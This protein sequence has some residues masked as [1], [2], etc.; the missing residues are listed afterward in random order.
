MQLHFHEVLWREGLVLRGHLFYVLLH[1]AVE[2]F[3]HW[4]LELLAEF[5][6][7]LLV[8]DAFDTGN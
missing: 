1:V 2:V 5:V 8:A 7:Q 6:F 3:V 4:Q